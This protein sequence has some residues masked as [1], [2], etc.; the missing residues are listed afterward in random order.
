MTV[1]SEQTSIPTPSFQ[2]QIT[3]IEERIHASQDDFMNC[4]W[5]AVGSAFGAG[6]LHSAEGR[7][8]PLAK[9]L[10][11][12]GI[13]YLFAPT[14]RPPFGIS[15]RI[16][17]TPYATVTVS[18][19]QLADLRKV[20]GRPGSLVPAVHIQA[21]VEPGPARTAVLRSAAVVHVGKLLDHA[22]TNNGKVRTNQLREQTFHAWEF[23][24]L[25][26]AGVLELLLPTPTLC[27]PFGLSA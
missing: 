13:D 1:T 26:R 14:G 25:Y 27:D 5:P 3:S 15:Q 19:K 16:G 12:S 2:P 20:W 23:L 22:E 9:Q 24:D 21:Y 11:W 8:D 17:R 6:E 7:D 18:E 4:V 10:D